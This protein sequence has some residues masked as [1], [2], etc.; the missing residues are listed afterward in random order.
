MSSMEKNV[1][2]LKEKLESVDCVMLDLDGTLF[3]LENLNFSTF[4]ATISQVLCYELTPDEYQTYFSGSKLRDGFNRFSSAKKCMT[5]DIEKLI[6]IFREIK[7]KALNEAIDEVVKVREGA[8]KFIQK[9]L[10]R[11]KRVCMVTSTNKDFTDIIIDRFGFRKYFEF[12]LTEDDIDVGK[13]NP[14]VYILALQNFSVTK[15]KAVA[16]EDSKN[17]ISSAMSAGIFCIGVYNKGL[18]DSYVE[19]ADVVVE[20]FNTCTKLL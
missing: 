17:G 9:L 8:E 15:E 2:K 20:D 7:G 18:N 4:K 13:P 11:G 1:Y 16:F 14:A 12:I 19:M 6:S 10:E 5:A 3:D